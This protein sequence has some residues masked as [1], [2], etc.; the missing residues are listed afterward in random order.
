MQSE[1]G[2]GSLIPDHLVHVEESLGMSLDVICPVGKYLE[3]QVIFLSRDGTT[4]MY[5]YQNTS[6][7][8]VSYT[9]ALI[10]SDSSRQK[11][12]NFS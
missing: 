11:K 8:L 10:R 12:L 4:Y 1:L 9:C 2:V 6:Y 5:I 3:A 7:E